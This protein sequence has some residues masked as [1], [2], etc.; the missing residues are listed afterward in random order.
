MFLIQQKAR[1]ADVELGACFADLE[2]NEK[3]VQAS[4]LIA[5]D[6][7]REAEEIVQAAMAL[8]GGAAASSASGS[9]ARGAKRK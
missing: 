1:A 7:L 4:S 5:E 9:G 6:Q 8:G 2:A 3:Q